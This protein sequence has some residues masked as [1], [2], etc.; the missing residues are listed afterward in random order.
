MDHPRREEPILD[1]DVNTSTAVL[2]WYADY[3]NL[4]EHTG[5]CCVCVSV[6]VAL[7]LCQTVKSNVA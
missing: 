4:L 7:W 2:E 6:G 5:C 1:V 3:S